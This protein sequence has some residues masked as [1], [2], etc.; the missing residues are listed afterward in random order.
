MPHSTEGAPPA[1]QPPPAVIIWPAAVLS[2]YVTRNPHLV[3]V[4]GNASQF[5]ASAVVSLAL[6][7]YEESTR[8]WRKVA[9]GAPPPVVRQFELRCMGG[10]GIGVLRTAT[11]LQQG[12]DALVQEALFADVAHIRD[13]LISLAHPRVSTWLARLNG[14]HLPTAAPGELLVP[15]IELLPSGPNG[16][17]AQQSRVGWREPIVHHHLV[18]R[19]HVAANLGPSTPAA[20]WSIPATGSSPEDTRA[21]ATQVH[22]HSYGAH[23]LLFHELS[24]MW[25][26]FDATAPGHQHT[27]HQYRSTWAFLRMFNCMLLWETERELVLYLAQHPEVPTTQPNHPALTLRRLDGFRALAS[28]ALGL[29]HDDAGEPRH[30]H[31]SERFFAWVMLYFG[32][33]QQRQSLA[34][35]CAVWLRGYWPSIGYDAHPEG[36]EQRRHQVVLRLVK[37]FERIV[38]LVDAVLGSPALKRP[39]EGDPTAAVAAGGDPATS[40]SAPPADHPAV[41]RARTLEPGSESTPQPGE[42][43]DADLDANARTAREAGMGADDPANV[44]KRL[45]AAKRYLATQTHPVIIPSYA[46]WFSLATLHPI[47]RRSLPEFFNSKNRSKT[48]TI[49][50]DYRDFMIHTYRLN[51]SEYLT[52]TAC[53]RN[54]AGDVCAIMRVHAFLEQ[55]GLINYQIDA[56]TRP[57][58]LGPPFTGH[59]RVLVDSPRGLAPLHPGT[60]PSTLRTDLLKTDPSRPAAP[61][62]RLSAASAQALAAQADAAHSAQDAARDPSRALKPC[63]TCGTTTPT[64]RYTSLKPFRAAGALPGAAAETVSLCGACYTEG[65]FPSALHA[66]DFVRLDADPFAH[67]ESDPWSDQ[68]VLLLLEGIEMHEDA[69]DRIA[70][71]VGT[72]TKEQCIAHFLRLPIED[73]FI[74]EVGAGAGG[75]L[76]GVD[77]VPLNKTDNPVMSVVA[78]LAGAVD[79]KTAAKAAGEA[80]EELDKGLKERADKAK[81]AK[82]EDGDD[83]MD[84]EAGEE[85]KEDGAAAEV[86]TNGTAEAS[87]DPLADSSRS[88]PSAN[89]Q[90]AA[91]TALGSA[92]AKAHALALQEDASLHSLVTAVV[93]AQVRK[94]D[95]KLKHFDELEALVEHERRALEVQKQQL[96]EDRLRVNRLLS[97]AAGL[98]QRA[99][100]NPQQVAPQEIGQVVSQLGSAPAQAVQVQNAGAP[101]AV[102]GEAVQLA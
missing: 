69:W 78:F 100:S 102:S 62:A 9:R 10:A 95:L 3:T 93:E 18:I 53:R 91:V 21:T 76:N 36:L 74:T 23:V 92:A 41:K 88:S 86:K 72:R 37:T 82:Q 99:K 14:A 61:D 87:E 17:T 63:H 98:V 38:Q 31:P 59:F 26:V 64:V 7:W 66:G 4:D 43:D 50:K 42:G 35:R 25:R 84:V 68:E 34:N 73:G 2:E 56:D 75:I 65:R 27:A 8:R 96:Y 97:E 12:T 49:Y 60:K 55:W 52:V 40:T 19:P 85:K 1:T 77:R 90:R 24:E 79:R 44:Q 54:L 83:K 39:A 70:D 5:S 57:S 58:S 32:A 16:G 67:A 33:P 22:L 20:I 13:E 81:A 101:P 47:E 45:I 48:P 11:P 89:L 80:I 30:Q 71:H 94:L 6:G 28:E 15:R 29:S 51:P 46:T